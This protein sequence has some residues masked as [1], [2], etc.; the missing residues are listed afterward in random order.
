MTAPAEAATLPVRE[1]EDRWTERELAE[2]RSELATEIVAL[3]EEIAAAATQIAAGDATDGAGD[4]LTDAGAKTYEREHE[5]ALVNNARDL[6]AQNE[7]AIERMDAGTY[8]VCESCGRPIGKGRLQAFPRA[9]L[10][11]TCKQREERR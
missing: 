1:G 2:V 8:G 10:C 6:L 11:V 3:R 7:R 4:D 9:T 5:M